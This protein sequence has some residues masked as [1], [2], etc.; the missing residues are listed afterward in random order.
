MGYII[1][2]YVKFGVGRAT[3]EAAQECRHKYI[4]REEAVGLLKI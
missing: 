3:D 4:T 2:V 1:G